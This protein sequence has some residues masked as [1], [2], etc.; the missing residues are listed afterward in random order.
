MNENAGWSTALIHNSLET[1]LKSSSGQEDLSCLVDNES[2]IVVGLTKAGRVFFAGPQSPAYKPFHEDLADMCLNKRITLNANSV[3][4]PLFQLECEF[5]DETEL[6]AISSYFSGLSNL[7]LGEDNHQHVSAAIKGIQ[8]YFQGL[9]ESEANFT[10]EIGLFG[11]LVFMLCHENVDEA[12]KA[13]HID[14]LDT[15]DFS[16]KGL[17]LEIKTT[18]R[19]VRIHH[20]R[21]TQ[22][23][24]VGENDFYYASI[25][26]P[27][28]NDGRSVE[29]AVKDLTL[30]ASA[31]GSIDLLEK[32]DSYSTSSMTRT[33]DLHTSMKSLLL[34][35]SIDV[36]KPT[37]RDHRILSVSWTCDFG[38]LDNVEKFENWYKMMAIQ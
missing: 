9:K 31:A 14:P 26:A 21:S 17:Q 24:L 25:Y 23:I 10:K 27:F 13:W 35:S 7:C 18:T 3:F 37:I 11:E 22:S 15:Y 32:L 4:E 19:P 20:L 2:K 5:Q 6:W 33:F 12:I 38:Q 34:F 28:A 1:L 16:G 30:R 8:H 36:P 29:D